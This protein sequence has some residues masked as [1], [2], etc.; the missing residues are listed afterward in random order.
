[1]APVIPFVVGWDAVVSHPRSY[2][3]PELHA[4]TQ[5]PEAAF[6]D[7]RESHVAAPRDGVEITFIGTPAPLPERHF[8]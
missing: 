1:M 5:G 4:L 7:W 2:T 6:C 3:G 8:R